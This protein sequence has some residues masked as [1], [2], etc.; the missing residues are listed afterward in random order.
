MTQL[1]CSFRLASLV[2]TSSNDLRALD[3]VGSAERAFTLRMGCAISIVLDRLEE[4]MQLSVS[5]FLRSSCSVSASFGIS[6]YWFNA[7]GP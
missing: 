6:V 3:P 2:D 4:W 5:Y 1:Q 7:F